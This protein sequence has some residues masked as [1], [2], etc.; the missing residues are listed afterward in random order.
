[1]PE[2]YVLPTD[3]SQHQDIYL[4]AGDN[5]TLTF[6]NLEMPEIVVDKYD[7]QTGEKLKGA[8]FAI[9]EQADTSRP[10][11]EGMTDTQGKFN[12]G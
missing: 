7:E 5:K 10:V 9:Y 1:M 2:P 11:A 8:Q 12:S 4:G 3:G 6:A